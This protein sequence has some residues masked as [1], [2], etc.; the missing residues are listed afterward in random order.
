MRAFRRMTGIL[1]PV[2]LIQVNHPFIF[3]RSVN[4]FG[5]GMTLDLLP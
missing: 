4:K 3:P 1:S 2:L 5:S